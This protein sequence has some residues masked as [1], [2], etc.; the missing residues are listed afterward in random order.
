MLSLGFVSM[1]AVAPPC[2]TR[3]RSVGS[4]ARTCSL[5][6]AKHKSS[7]VFNSSYAMAVFL[8]T[9]TKTTAPWHPGR[10]MKRRAVDVKVTKRAAPQSSNPSKTGAGNASRGVGGEENGSQDQ[11]Q[12]FMGVVSLVQVDRHYGF[13]E[14]LEGMFPVLV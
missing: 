11:D 5:S 2:G 4:F 14:V 9:S 7:V 8:G 3:C 12:E 10:N 13:I 6:L 1:F